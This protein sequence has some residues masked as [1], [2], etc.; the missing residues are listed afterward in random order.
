MKKHINID[1]NSRRKLRVSR[2]IFGT[3]SRPR[4]S[5]FRSNRFIYAQAIDDEK[6]KTIMT[7]SS[8]KLE[9]TRKK[10]EDSFSVGQKLSK[11]LIEKGI[12]EGVFDRGKY[13]YKGRVKALAEGMRS[14]KFKI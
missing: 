5:V 9:K 12:K 4:I 6:R 1:R 2:N 8:V 10:T 13:S 11:L 14:E 3:S 7:F